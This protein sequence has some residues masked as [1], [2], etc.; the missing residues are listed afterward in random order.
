MNVGYFDDKN[1]ENKDLWRGT[2]KND[3]SQ[4]I[5]QV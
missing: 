3:V 4:Q 2:N 1:G 5:L